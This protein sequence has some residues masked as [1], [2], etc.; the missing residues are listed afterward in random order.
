MHAPSKGRADVRLVEHEFWHGEIK[1]GAVAQLIQED[2]LRINLAKAPPAG[3]S[4]GGECQQFV[5]KWMWNC[6]E[7]PV[8]FSS[9]ETEFPT[10]PLVAQPVDVCQRGPCK[11]RHACASA[12]A[13]LHC[14]W[15]QARSAKLPDWAPAMP[16]HARR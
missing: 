2:V 10:T 8:G 1:A 11:L 15:L 4:R 12:A 9:F 3:R 6:V 5:K 13:R 16:L 7:K 14:L